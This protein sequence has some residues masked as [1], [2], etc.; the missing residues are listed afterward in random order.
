MITKNKRTNKTIVLAETVV[1]IALV[2][3]ATTILRVPI[4]ATAGY[5]NIGDGIIYAAALLFGPLVGGLAGGIGSAIADVIGYPIF[6]P[7]TLII[8]F[9]EGAVTGY[10]GKK[11]RPSANTAT[12]WKYLSI[13][14]GIGLGSATYYIGINY[15]GVFV[16]NLL[17]QILWITLSLFLAIFIIFVSFKPKSG[18]TVQTSAIILGGAIMVAGYF[19]YE[20]LLAV[21]FP[22]LAIYAIGE[23]PFNIGQV[24]VGMVIALPVLRA[25][26]RAM[27]SEQKD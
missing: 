26:K 1:F 5:F 7:G 17:N 13:I 22:G 19:L 9:F 24:L 12:F 6:A 15:M 27:P 23:I 14:L 20:N 3:V 10:I 16:N 11:I 8:K 2:F 4:P 18:T 21:L 25:A